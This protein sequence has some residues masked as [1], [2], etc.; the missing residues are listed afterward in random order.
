MV[1]TLQP[2]SDSP[3][4]IEAPAPL[5]RVDG[6]AEFQRLHEIHLLDVRGGSPGR[7]ACPCGG[8]GAHTRPAHLVRHLLAIRYTDSDGV[9]DWV[10]KCDFAYD[11]KQKKIVLLKQWIEDGEAENA[12]RELRGYTQGARPDQR[13]I[14]W[15][16]EQGYVETTDVTNMQSTGREFLIKRITDKGN[17]LLKAKART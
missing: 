12:F 13:A 11:F 4:A 17:R 3:Q 2:W 10:T 6:P 14:K 16:H 1:E 7:L 5:P 8:F 15:L 9:L